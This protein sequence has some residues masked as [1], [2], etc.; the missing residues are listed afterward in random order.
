MGI[1]PQSYVFS[2]MKIVWEIRIPFNYVKSNQLFMGAEKIFP[3]ATN[4]EI[5]YSN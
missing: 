5:Y 4:Y 1:E 3:L 2:L